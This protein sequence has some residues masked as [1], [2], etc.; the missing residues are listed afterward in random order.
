MALSAL[1]N[2]V[3]CVPRAS[4]SRS[5]GRSSSGTPSRSA[6]TRNV[7]GCAKSVMNSP[8]PERRKSS[9][10]S[11][12]SCHIASSFSFSRFGVMLDGWC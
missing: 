1:P 7:K 4:L 2:P 5:S 10:M 3:P 9:R 6:M 11:S 12:A 8:S